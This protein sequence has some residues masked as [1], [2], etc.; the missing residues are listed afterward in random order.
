MPKKRLG[1]E[2]IVTKLRQVEALRSQGKSV[3]AA[4][5]EVGPLPHLYLPPS[6]L[7]IRLHPHTDKVPGQREQR[8]TQSLTKLVPRGQPLPN[9]KRPGSKAEEDHRHRN[10]LLPTHAQATFLLG[11]TQT[12]IGVMS[13]MIVAILSGVAQAMPKESPR[14]Q[15]R[16]P[17]LG[18]GARW[19][20]ECAAE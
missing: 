10:A 4:F 12:S 2:Q 6:S 14:G 7:L 16:K 8:F 15:R 17:C 9:E 11:M 13:P 18:A 3:A 5:K 20:P 19:L 1:A